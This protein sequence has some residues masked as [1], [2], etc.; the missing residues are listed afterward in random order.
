MTSSA[1]AS[2]SDLSWN[3]S[4][5]EENSRDLLE[6]I[7]YRTSQDSKTSL[8]FVSSVFFNMFLSKIKADFFSNVDSD[9]TTT[10]TKCVTHVQGLKCEII[11][12]SHFNTVTVT[13]VGHKLWRSH[14]F[15]KAA[16][17]LFKRFVQ[18]VNS[19]TV[20]IAKANLCKLQT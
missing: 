6:R 10:I 19:M 1:S 4:A 11:L 3:K 15:P 9:N 18:E 13:G 17:S 8:I 14:Y 2:A 20:K 12:D 16:Q 5:R 7:F